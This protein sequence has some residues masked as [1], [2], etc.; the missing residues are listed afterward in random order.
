[1]FH[2]EGRKPLFQEAAV[3]IRMMG[4]DEDDPAKQIIDG[5]FVDPMTSGHLI[6]NAGDLRDLR[7]DGKAGI[8]E[9]FP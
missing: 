8:F 5:L 4:D 9:P 6:G 7:W 3:E 1:M 2:G